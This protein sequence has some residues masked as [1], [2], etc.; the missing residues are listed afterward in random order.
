MTLTCVLG[1]VLVCYCFVFLHQT[2]KCFCEISVHLSMRQ[3]HN[4]PQ[5]AHVSKNGFLRE[6]RF[7]VKFFNQLRVFFRFNWNF[8]LVMRTYY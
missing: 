7:F 5:D 1:T 4:M 3:C 2:M 8:F 6:R